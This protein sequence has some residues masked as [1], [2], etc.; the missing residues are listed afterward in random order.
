[1]INERLQRLQSR[2]L[3]Q[4][5]HRATALEDTYV[6]GDTDT[7]MVVHLQHVFCR[8]DEFA[9]DMQLRRCDCCC[10]TLS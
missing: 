10:I 1:M 6:R 8:L 4:M 9:E 3:V 5:Q 2:Q 7:D